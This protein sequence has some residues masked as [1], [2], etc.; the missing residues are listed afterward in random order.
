[1]DAYG[2]IRT[3]KVICME[4][5]LHHFAVYRLQKHEL[6]MGTRPNISFESRR[7]ASAAQLRR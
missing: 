4:V 7:S 2:S 1:M 3:R 5:D 6:G